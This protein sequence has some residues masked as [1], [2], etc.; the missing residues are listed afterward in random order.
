MARESDL[1]SDAPGTADPDFMTSFARGLAVLQCFAEQERPMTVARAS[2]LTGLSR[3]S[4]RRCLHTLRCLGL[5]EQQ[6][7]NYVLLPGVLRLGYAYLS[8]N[9][10]AVAAQPMLEAAA[11][12]IG[13]SCSLGARDG[14]EL[15]YVARA[16][17]SR[18]LSIALGIGTRLPLYCTSMGRVLLAHSP[19]EEQRAYLD[20]IALVRRTADTLTDKGRLLEE[21]ET[22]RRQ[23]FALVDQELEVGLRSVAVPVIGRN[24]NVIAAVNVGTSSLRVSSETLLGEHMPLLKEIA[25]ELGR[26]A[27]RYSGSIGLR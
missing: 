6:E 10:L 11:A 7:Q 27:L 23:G 21:F 20:R 24:G 2:E 16:E 19:R 12:R 8:S 5:A 3:G 13:E 14:D 26:L 22:I 18:I 4:V 25:A 1:A 15:C 17:A 9:A